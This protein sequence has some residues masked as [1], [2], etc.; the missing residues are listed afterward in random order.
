MDLEAEVTT[1]IQLWVI[2]LKKSEVHR[3]ED[4]L[5]LVDSHLR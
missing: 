3:A 1:L 4:W 5:H 2:A